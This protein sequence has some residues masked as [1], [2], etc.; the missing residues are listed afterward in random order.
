MMSTSTF[1]NSI[2][3]AEEFNFSLVINCGLLIRQTARQTDWPTYS[4]LPIYSNW[5]S[6][7]HIL[8]SSTATSQEEPHHIIHPSTFD[9][10]S[11]PI[12]II[13]NNRPLLYNNML[14]VIIII[15]LLFNSIPFKSPSF[16]RAKLKQWICNKQ[17]ISL[18]YSTII[19]IIHNY[20]YNAPLSAGI[21][22]YQ[23]NSDRF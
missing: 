20:F 16:T 23:L 2:P 18:Y 22:C 14:I 9:W 13:L 8:Q 7:E 3:P 17:F 21:S 15:I 1:Y 5:F 12:I 4:K 10:T 6:I 19:I 11:S